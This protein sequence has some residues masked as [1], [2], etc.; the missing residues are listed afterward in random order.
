[1]IQD[2]T[3]A[4]FQVLTSALL[5]CR[6]PGKFFAEAEVA[7]IALLL[8]ARYGPELRPAESVSG[9]GGNVSRFSTSRNEQ[10]LS[11]EQQ[12]HKGV[13]ACQSEHSVASLGT[14]PG[15]TSAA[16]DSGLG[17]MSAA[18][19]ACAVDSDTSVGGA[20][21]WYPLAG[22]TERSARAE[23]AECSGRLCG[24][25]LADQ[26]SNDRECSPDIPVLPSPELRRQVGVRWPQHDILIVLGD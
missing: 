13:E 8:L 4:I 16:R 21:P 24:Q 26:D 19:S 2:E 5:T 1:M 14:C 15:A 22:L 7:L 3:L 10:C 12:E 20:K 9:G 6:C 25:T 17:A 18:A 11:A 23:Q